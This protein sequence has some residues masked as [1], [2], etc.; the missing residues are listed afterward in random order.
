MRKWEHKEKG[1]GELETFWKLGFSHFY[2]ACQGRSNS[3]LSDNSIHCTVHPYTYVNGK[4]HNLQAFNFAEVN[5][6]NKKSHSSPKCWSV[7][8]CGSSFRES[9]CFFEGK[10]KWYNL[11]HGRALLHCGNTMKL[12]LSMHTIKES[13]LKEN[14]ILVAVLLS[15]E[16]QSLIYGLVY[17]LGLKGCLY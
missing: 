1:D 5:P 10:I 7:W 12:G 3:L 11:E 2:V 14:T 8:D 13:L 15:R 6:V 9:W 4:C 16:L 17:S